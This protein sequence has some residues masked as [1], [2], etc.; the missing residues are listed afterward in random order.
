[1]LKNINAAV[2]SMFATREI[3]DNLHFNY[4]NTGV[5]NEFWTGAR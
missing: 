2:Q 1:M 3:Y 4:E 5:L